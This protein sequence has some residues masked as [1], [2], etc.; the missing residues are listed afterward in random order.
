MPIESKTPRA[1]IHDYT[2]SQVE[3]LREV[4]I[5]R[6]S[7]IGEKVVNH[8]RNL[9]SPSA[10]S[11]D[12]K[13]IPPHQPNYIDW[14]ANLRSSIGYVIVADG[15]VVRQSDFK[16][17]S[18]GS[19]GSAQGREFANSLATQFPSGVCLI[20]VAGMNYAQYV[21]AKGYDVIDTSE[22]L[23]QQL[24]PEMLNKLGLTS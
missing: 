5:M 4:L 11:F 16:P 14:T 3:R 21:S 9:P 20:V 12:S 13:R 19:E 2:V 7:L 18:G 17:V 23:A 10:A 15:Q 6:L 24:V 8:A 1:A 22:Q